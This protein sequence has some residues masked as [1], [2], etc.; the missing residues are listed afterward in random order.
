MEVIM[1]PNRQKMIGDVFGTPDEDRTCVLR[2]GSLI[3]YSKEY[4]RQIHIDSGY[5]KML[6]ES[7]AQGKGDIPIPRLSEDQIHEASR[8][9][10]DV[11]AHYAGEHFRPRIGII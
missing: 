10:Y 7:R 11:A 5:Y 2:E 1:G 3:H 8:R 4:L 6:Q 9:Y